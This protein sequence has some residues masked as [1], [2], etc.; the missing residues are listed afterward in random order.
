LAFDV[1][2]AKIKVA[3]AAVATAF[4]ILAVVVAIVGKLEAGQA[5]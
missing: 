1:A 4:T 2:P 3:V 5:T